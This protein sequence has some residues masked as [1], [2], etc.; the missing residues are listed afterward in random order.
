MAT[1]TES[2]RLALLNAEE[3]EALYGLPQFD[4]EERRIH[5]ELLPEEHAVIEERTPAV[6]IILA[7]ELGYFKAKH[8]FFSY[9]LGAVSQDLGHLRALYFSKLDLT[10]LRLP[11]KTTRVALNKVVLKLTG[12]RPCDAQAMQALEKRA[13]QIAKRSAQPQYI[14][15]ETLQFLENERIITPQYTTLQDVIGRVVSY[16]RSRVVGLLK[17]TIPRRIKQKLN[18]LLTADD[19]LYQI[20]ALKKEARDFS[21]RELK[22]EV[23]RRQVFQPLHG[24]ATKFLAEAGLSNESSRYYASLVKFY[25]VY[26][27][28]RMPQDASRLYLLCF[29]H[30][31]FREIND[32]LIEAFM[33]LVFT[34]KK[35]AK[36]A[37]DEVMKQAQLDATEN[38]GAAGHILRLF[39]DP[40]IKPDSPFANIQAKAFKL[41][42][43]EQFPTVSDYLLKIDF[44]RAAYQW[45]QYTKLSSRF[46]LNLR[47]L[48]CELEF[49]VRVDNAPLIK[50]VEFLQA[51]LRGGKSPR[52][53]PPE[54]FPQHFIAQVHRPYL[55][56]D[57]ENLRGNARA[58][59]LIV[60]RY[61]FLVYRELCDALQAGDVFVR[62]SDEYKRFED[63]LINDERWKHKDQIL[64]DIGA[65][66]LTTPIETTLGTLR[67]ALES[68]FTEVNQR[69]E[70][71]TN[72]H[73]RIRGKG[74][75]RRWT[76][77]YPSTDEPVNS[78][79]YTQLPG[80]DIADLLWFVAGRTKFLG[81]FTH[82]LD[83]YV[84][85]VPDQ[86]LILAGIVAMGTNMGL[87]KMAEVSGLGFSQLQTS[88]R[89]YLR[90]ETLRAAND[91]VSNATA[92]LP[93]F[94]LYNIQNKL[95][96]SSD[97]QRFETQINTFNSRYSP[98]YF[99]LKKG[100]SACTLVANHVP[101][102]ARI[103]GTQE[104]ESHYVF[105]LLYN[106]TSD[107]KPERHS[108]DTHGT[109]RVNFLI[110]QTFSYG[111]APRY[112]NLRQKT[113]TL[114][115]SEPPSHYLGKLIRPERKINEK[116]IIAEWPN[117]QRILASLAEKEVSQATIVRK[118]SSYALQNQTKK[119][120][121]ELDD[122]Y[123]TLYVLDFIDHADLRQAVQKALN[124]G[125]AYHRFRKAVAFV[126]TGAFRVKTEAEQALWNEC[127]RLIANAVIFYNT[128][129]LS[130]IY[131]QKLAAGD[132]TAIEILRGI[133]PVAWQHVNLFGSFEFSET[134]AMVDLDAMAALY[135]RVEYW[136][137]ATVKE[138]LELEIR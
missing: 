111:F 42:K 52:Q 30:Q 123:R 107:I 7:L 67:E 75:N 108:T 116:L 16:E 92:L 74:D 78:P 136:Q 21:R 43:R 86:R 118:L 105:D 1:A 135:G 53:I 34:Y 2:H 83:R 125:E 22:E 17:K 28:Q 93:A 31:R 73:I 46:K 110:L 120:L 96:S 57:A 133:S 91:A 130:R 26:K 69:I 126:N 94:K 102:N 124:R 51:V 65:P 98:K 27:L 88:S 4:E 25:T 79:F 117:I 38:L 37:A 129:L 9:E 62:H 103:I 114:V 101:I 72:E 138:D 84:K 47:H 132:A 90:L 13:R 64:K 60:D 6:G 32:N 63:D 128:A 5:F 104:H 54:N 89:N 33:H 87:G 18:E 106:N 70:D 29:A 77:A 45:A 59:R 137:Q 113:E 8:R 15:R 127:S 82:V 36:V 11:A 131:E 35:D 134:G 58:K 121:W 50:A 14:L 10:R 19:S 44:D 61:E 56:Q 3:I 20:S 99:G 119:A 23:Q 109:N 48:F 112:K 80:T 76:L 115:G 97:G 68:R 49:G 12:Y 41:L 71:S 100:V 85:Q 81:K 40:A 95:H 39:I 66:L 122:I 24:F 55:Y